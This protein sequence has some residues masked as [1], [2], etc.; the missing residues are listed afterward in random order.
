MNEK[1]KCPTVRPELW[2]FL[3]YEVLRDFFQIMV[4]NPRLTQ[5]LSNLRTPQSIPRVASWGPKF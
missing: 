5:A 3:E 2:T 1:S 4:V